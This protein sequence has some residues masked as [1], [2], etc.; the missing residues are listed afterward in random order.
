MYDM[1]LRLASVLATPFAACKL[2]PNFYLQDG[3]K[4]A[5]PPPSHAPGCGAVAAC[6]L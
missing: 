3:G 2:P 4:S 5:D 1:S 6:G